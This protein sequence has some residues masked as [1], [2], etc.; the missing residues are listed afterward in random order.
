MLDGAVDKKGTAYPRVN[1]W[2]DEDSF[3][4]EAEVPG[5]AADDLDVSALGDRITIKGSRGEPT[6]EGATQH[7]RELR[8]A[9]FERSFQLPIDVDGTKIQA[10]LDQGIL[11]LTLP[12]VPE[13]KPVK[14]KVLPQKS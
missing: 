9:R 7:R 8:A 4:F 2:E 6:R 12:K 5:F 1:I 10:E 13:Q 3:H 11:R 14:I